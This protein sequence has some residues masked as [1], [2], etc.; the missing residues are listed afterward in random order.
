MR[1][2]RDADFGMSTP[3]LSMDER[4]IAPEPIGV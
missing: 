1:E 4:E 3:Q 2:D